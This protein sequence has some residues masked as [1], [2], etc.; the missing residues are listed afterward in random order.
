[1]AAMIKSSRKP[2]AE[3]NQSA[4]SGSDDMT[5][6]QFLEAQCDSILDDLRQ[7]SANLIEQ[8]KKEFAEGAKSITL[9]MATEH[10]ESRQKK[11]CVTLKVASGPHLGQKFRLEP[12]T[13]DGEDVFKIGRSTG[14]AF[15]EKGLSLYK[16]KEISTSH[17]K[18]DVR[19][20]QAFLMDTKS[21]NG[22]SLNGDDVEPN[23]PFRLKTGDVIS[24]GGTEL[25]VTISDI[26]GEAEEGGADEN[27]ASV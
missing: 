17:A 11:L 3:T 20:G 27:F 9:M 14:K 10:G 1:M 8:L 19:N 12:S 5:V 18:I 16:D 25:Q 24:L 26:D 4:K 2:L 22:T 21:T 13:A 15:K 6:E 7:H 23:L